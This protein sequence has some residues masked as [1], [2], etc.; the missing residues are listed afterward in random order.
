MEI[1]FNSILK[2][3]MASFVE[4]I[5]LD[6]NH[7]KTV[8]AYQHT[9]SEFDSFLCM[10]RLAEKKLQADRIKYWLDGFHTHISTKKSKLSRLKRFAKY[11]STIGIPASLP[12]LPKGTTDFK[13]YVFTPDEMLQI[14]EL[15]DDLILTN[16]N[17]RTAA[18]LPMLLRLL[19]GCGLRLG[20][21]TSL[22]WDDIDLS[23]GV[24]TVKAAKYK[25]QRKVPMSEELSRILKLYQ[26]APCFEMQEH[27]LLF[28]TKEGRKRT[29]GTYGHVFTRILC[30]L[31]IRNPQTVK[32]S[33]RGPC[34]HSLRHTFTLHSLM[35]A[36]SKGR[37]F[38]E[39]VPFLSTYLGH[40]GLMETDK[41]LKARH[42]LYTGAHTAIADYTCDIFP[43]EV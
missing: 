19:Y 5:K 1:L 27:G 17:S 9:L 14:F 21:A 40:V 13:P 41:Y 33:A 4:F 20:E 26:S 3:E 18:E 23:I 28:K 22:T 29:A 36:E 37:G 12:E 8:R 35:K 11:L 25:K 42:E 31:S 32:R 34:L 7:S 30:E 24:I 16:P 39:T 38:M 6:N 43:G 2:D 15:A 10:E